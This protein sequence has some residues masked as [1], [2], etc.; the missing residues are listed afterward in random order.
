MYFIYSVYSISIMES[1]SERFASSRPL[2]TW[3]QSP[4]LEVLIICGPFLD[5][6]NDK[7]GDA[8]GDRLGECLG[9]P[10][11]KWQ[12]GWHVQCCANK[13]KL[14]ETNRKQC[15]Q[16]LLQGC[17]TDFHPTNSWI[18]LDRPTDLSPKRVRCCLV[19]FICSIERIET[20][21]CEGLSFLSVQYYRARKNKHFAIDYWNVGFLEH[22]I[23][24]PM[25][26][27][28]SCCARKW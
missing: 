2:C 28:S 20:S 4:D 26:P 23:P 18:Q 17:N 14:G 7:V 1:R 16:L 8:A 9:F 6:N 21:M 25:A 19:R 5:C 12:Q 3:H 27:F 24:S 11:D 15:M 22:E 10:H 13:L